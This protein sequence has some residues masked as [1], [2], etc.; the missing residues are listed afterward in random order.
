MSGLRDIARDNRRGNR[1]ELIAEI[2]DSSERP[3]LS[4]GAI[5]EGIDQPTGEAADN[6]PMARLIHNRATTCSARTP[7]QHTKAK[8]SAPDQDGVPHQGSV[9]PALHQFVD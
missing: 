7:P 3:T 6:P 4:R 1:R 5:K 8:G 2:Q 9:A